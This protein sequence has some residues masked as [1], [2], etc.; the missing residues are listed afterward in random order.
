MRCCVQVLGV[1]RLG[2]TVIATFVVCWSPWLTSLDSASQVQQ[3]AQLPDMYSYDNGTS[4]SK[5]TVRPRHAAS[6][7]HLS[8]SR[9][10]CAA[11]TAQ[12]DLQHC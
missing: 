11:F 6:Q 12:S 10:S 8:Q 9:A 4:S 3:T 2:V 1:A 5:S 7:V